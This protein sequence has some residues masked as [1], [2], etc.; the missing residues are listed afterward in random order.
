M[1]HICGFVMLH[2]RWTSERHCYVI[3]AHTTCN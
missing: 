3:G 1:G 2:L